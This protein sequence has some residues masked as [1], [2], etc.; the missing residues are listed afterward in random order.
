MNATGIVRRITLSVLWRNHGA[1]PP[2]VGHSPSTGVKPSIW[3]AWAERPGVDDAERVYRPKPSSEEEQNVI[4]I[5][6]Q[7]KLFGPECKTGRRSGRRGA[8]DQTDRERCIA[9]GFGGHFLSEMMILF[10]PRNLQV[11]RRATC[12]SGWFAASERTGGA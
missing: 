6:C 3:A 11:R 2:L 8:V 7:D 12:K 4:V 9:S 5:G 1:G 10:F